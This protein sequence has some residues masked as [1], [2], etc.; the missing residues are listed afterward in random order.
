[1]GLDLNSNGAKSESE[2][3]HWFFKLRMYMIFFLSYAN[4]MPG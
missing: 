3:Q 1:M 4:Q 2:M